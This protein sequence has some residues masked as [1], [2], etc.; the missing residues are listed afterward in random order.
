[1]RASATNIG[2]A[3]LLLLTF[4]P[5]PLRAEDRTPARPGTLNYIEG[6]V[7][8]GTRPLNSQSVG[9]VEL[10]PG[11]TLDT[12][13]GKAE[14][15]LI[16]GVFVR[17]GDNAAARMVSSDLTFT[18]ISLDEGEAFV[19]V[20]QIQPENDLRVIEDGISTRLQKVGL[21]DFDENLHVVRVL[22]GEA[23]LR[24]G[25]RATKI[26]GG[27]FVSLSATGIVKAQKFDKKSVEA[28]DLY[29]WTSLRSGYLAEA[30]ADISPIYPTGGMGWFG[31]GWYWDPWFD[32]Y[33]F[34]PGD[35]IFYSPFGWGFYSP[36]CAF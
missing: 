29:R 24:D 31:E 36:S 23:I 22:D 7:Y 13:N 28:E 17:L 26:K 15:L 34:M 19:E 27:H 18:E 8:L 12:R 1:M 6:Q 25:D 4:L 33:T 3:L 20:V 14:I 10:Q 35:G 16:P 2:Y 9:T 30:N 11:Q 32:A 5:P 21:Y